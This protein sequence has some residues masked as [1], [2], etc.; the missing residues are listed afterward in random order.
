LSIEVDVFELSMPEGAEPLSVD[1]TCLGEPTL[2]ARVDTDKDDTLQVRR[3]RVVDSGYE[4]KAGGKFVG[5]LYAQHRS[6]PAFHVFDLGPL[7]VETVDEVREVVVGERVQLRDLGL[8][9]SLDRVDEVGAE[10]AVNEAIKWADMADRIAAGEPTNELPPT[11]EIMRRA[12]ETQLGEFVDILEADGRDHATVDAFTF[13][14]QRLQERRDLRA[15]VGADESY[16]HEQAVALAMASA[17]MQRS[18]GD[19]SDCP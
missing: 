10:A 15:A 9:L 19:G 14:R 4:V 13:L 5:V 7:C 18:A 2:W 12:V 8:R 17:R 1:R 3:F 11:S 16:T 6:M